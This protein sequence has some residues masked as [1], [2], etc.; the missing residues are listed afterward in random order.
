M[1]CEM[2]TLRSFH[3]VQTVSSGSQAPTKMFSVTQK[4]LAGWENTLFS[5]SMRWLHTAQRG[6]YLALFGMEWSCLIDAHH[7]PLSH[8]RWQSMSRVPGTSR[9]HF[10]LH[11]AFHLRT[12]DGNLTEGGYL[13]RWSV[14]DHRENH[15]THTSHRATTLKELRHEIYSCGFVYRESTDTLLWQAL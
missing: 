7:E 8:V 6:Y 11:C 12:A 15:K 3:S 4:H 10:R 9:L 14:L 5:R 1:G 13:S 2:A